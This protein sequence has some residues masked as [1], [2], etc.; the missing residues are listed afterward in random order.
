MLGSIDIRFQVHLRSRH[1]SVSV[2]CLIYYLPYKAILTFVNIASC[3]YSIYK[4]AKYFAKRHPKIIEDEGALAVVIKLEEFE[5]EKV[6]SEL[7]DDRANKPSS[8]DHVSD[9]DERRQAMFNKVC[10]QSRRFS[11]TA[12]GTNLSSALAQQ[13]DEIS[14]T[15]ENDLADRPSLFPRYNSRSRSQRNR[16]RT[17]SKAS[18]DLEVSP[19]AEREK[20]L[21][22]SPSRAVLT[23]SRSKSNSE[24]VPQHRMSPPE[25]PSLASRIFNS[26]SFDRSLRRQSSNTSDSARSRSSSS[27][28]H[29]TA[30]PR[31][32]DA[33]LSDTYSGG[34]LQVPP[35]V[36]RPAALSRVDE[37]LEFDIERY[38]SA[39]A[40]TG[41]R[42]TSR[43]A[44][45]P[46]SSHGRLFIREAE[47][48][49]DQIAHESGTRTS[50][51]SQ[52]SSLASRSR[53]S[54]G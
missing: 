8:D 19:Q 26:F 20:P 25:R 31:E 3:Y 34:E 29:V 2:L 33:I 9:F 54:I 10:Y 27:P 47:E 37:M 50:L 35:Q 48:E 11:I 18:G 53:V 49:E 7:E 23:N 17:L 15:D 45:R 43:P 39:L 12:V 44:S 4:Y 38:V 28:H 52:R 6:S 41:S 36:Y 13:E 46:A 22:P 14:E 30:R 51:I 24:S 40:D 32:Q 5:E 42:A 21:F 1:E 16:N